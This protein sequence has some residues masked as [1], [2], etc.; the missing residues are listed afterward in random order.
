MA[1]AALALAACDE[2]AIN[3]FELAGID[4]EYGFLVLATEGGEPTQISPLFEVGPDQKLNGELPVY[5]LRKNETRAVLI[6]LDRETLSALL[7]SF[8]ASR[9]AA[10]LARLAAPPPAPQIEEG[11]DLTVRGLVT[12]A[13]PPGARL[14]A[15]TA[16]GRDNLL[17]VSPADI[18]LQQN[19]RDRVSL[20][21]PVDH[22]YCRLAGAS[23]LLPIAE[24]PAAFA[25][26][27]THPADYSFRDTKRLGDGRVVMISWSG[28][29][30]AHEDEPWVLGPE[31]Y[32]RLNFTGVPPR[33]LA[34]D[35]TPAPDGRTRIVV[36]GGHIEN[37][38]TRFAGYW[39]LTAGERDLKLVETATIADHAFGEVAVGRDG[40]IIFGL[41]K[42]PKL[43]ER[44]A[45]ES[46]TST[47]VPAFRW[48]DL[49]MRPAADDTTQVTATED[50]EYPF[51]V[52]SEGR[53]HLWRTSAGAWVSRDFDQPGLLRL[54][55]ARPMDVVAEGR[56]DSF[57]VWVGAQYGQIF[58]FDQT[59]IVE[60]YE[61]PL[62]PR[63]Y[64]CSK[65]GGPTPLVSLPN[66]STLGVTSERVFATLGG[67]NPLFVIARD[68]KCAQVILR[69]DAPIKD[70][71]PDFHA[72]E[73]V[74]RSLVAG[75]ENGMLMRTTW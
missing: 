11:P 56:G 27:G 74:G 48:V 30:L 17:E 37:E 53:L 43:Y 46:M 2:R 50:D 66:I 18:V 67:C 35:P 59:P 64:P 14:H 45:P 71:E 13:L 38:D 39:I 52:A 15:V 47:V 60:R 9:S 31:S 62:P 7:P 55:L 23:S 34:I 25:G 24:S 57:G 41:Q 65:S 21:V 22:E 29:F 12:T 26:V 51:A 44:P 40:R 19:V 6:A 33:A 3:Q 61:V 70:M 20:E 16:E 58:Y 5:A 42:E 32:L 72:T 75:G 63:G 49:P 8:D 54:E 28:I 69:D 4:F 73:L 68:F 36:S 10:L 1:I